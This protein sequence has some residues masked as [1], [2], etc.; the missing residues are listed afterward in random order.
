MGKTT[1]PHP[2]DGVY[3]ENR[4]Y[5]LRPDGWFKWH[6]REGYIKKV[7]YK[8]KMFIA[9][10]YHS[11]EEVTYDW[12]EFETEETRT[13]SVWL[14]T[15]EPGAEV[16]RGPKFKTMHENAERVISGDETEEKLPLV[17]K[18]GNPKW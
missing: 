8:E 16:W 11:R 14:K 4:P 7:L 17:D 9:L 15:L 13:G 5:E 1:G 12:D 10:F 3:D 2:G 18:E 6:D